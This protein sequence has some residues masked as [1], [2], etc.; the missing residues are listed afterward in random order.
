[1][2]PGLAAN[3]SKKK[4]KKRIP[5]LWLCTP[6]V[7]FSPFQFPLVLSEPAYSG[8]CP[9]PKQDSLPNP[10]NPKLKFALQSQSQVI[11]WKRKKK[12]KKENFLSHKNITLPLLSTLFILFQWNIIPIS[13]LL[14]F[15]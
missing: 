10:S 6:A 5:A 1:M 12:K 15:G 8:A 14:I 9:D 13:L 7:A 2:V 3:I 4:K 11:V